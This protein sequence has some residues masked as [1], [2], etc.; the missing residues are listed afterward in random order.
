MKIIFAPIFFLTMQFL[1]SFNYGT[2]R[3]RI[4]LP[5]YKLTIVPDSCNQVITKK[6]QQNHKYY[7]INLKSCQGKMSL[8][9]YNSQDSA[10]LEKGNYIASLDL[11]KSY[12]NGL[13]IATGRTTIQVIKYYQ[14]L[15]DG[16]WYYY[17]SNGVTK[18]IYK[19][20]ILQEE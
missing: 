5:E 12:G 1:F 7:I 16:I 9:C 19:C 15:K 2:G 4:E 3:Y 13:D 10:L 14:P 11:L 6:D 8:E 18:K 20:G 17:N